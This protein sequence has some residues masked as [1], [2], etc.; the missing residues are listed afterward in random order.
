MHFHSYKLNHAKNGLKLVLASRSSTDSNG[1]AKL[2]GLNAKANIGFNEIANI[3]EGK[4]SDS[5][6]LSIVY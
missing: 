5:T 4:I 6:I 1:I 3:L 2:L